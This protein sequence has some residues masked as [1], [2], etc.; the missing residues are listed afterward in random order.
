[1]SDPLRIAIMDFRKKVE[2]HLGKR[3]QQRL[4]VLR[5]DDE[6]VPGVAL[7][8]FQV[9]GDIQMLVA[10]ITAAAVR[11]IH[12]YHRTPPAEDAPA[13]PAPP[14]PAVPVGPSSGYTA[15]I[16]QRLAPV[17]NA[18]AAPSAT[19]QFQ[20]ILDTEMAALT[21]ES[22]LV[23]KVGAAFVP[24][25]KNAEQAFQAGRHS[26]VITILKS[27]LRNEPHNGILLFIASQF[28]YFMASSGQQDALPAAR[29][30]AQKAMIFSDRLP[31]EK[32]AYYRYHCIATE[33]A[34]DMERA[35]TWI[36]EHNLLDIAPLLDDAGLTAQGGMPLKMW[37]VLATIPATFW[38][39]PEL[40]A[41]EQLVHQVI[42]G[43]VLY[44]A[45]LRPKLIEAALGR[46][47]PQPLIDKIENDLSAAYARY[48]AIMPALEQFPIAVGQLPWLVRTRYLNAIA[49]APRP[50]FDHVLL[51][52]N[53]HGDRWQNDV[54]PETEVQHALGER[55]LSY[56]RLWTYALTLRK[57][58]RQPHLLPAVEGLADAALLADA[59]ALLATLRQGEN[60]RIRPMA[61]EEIQPWMIKWQI[62]HLL[63]AGTGTSQPRDTFVPQ[64]SPFNTLY[65]R[66]NDPSAAGLLSSEMIYTTAQRGGFADVS[67]ILTAFEGA[68]RLIDDP[69]YGLHATQKRALKAAKDH[70]PG[71]YDHLRIED[72][73]SGAQFLMMLLPLVLMGGI[74]AVMMM[75]RNMGQAIGLSLALAGF[76]GVAMISLSRK[77]G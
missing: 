12:A 19:A 54:Y 31:P 46:K 58:T 14:P 59:D 75:S 77:D 27:A 10:E 73:F 7:K 43:A 51:H 60:T 5:E 64:I 76:I 69:T 35:L 2:G 39:E 30:M 22:A 66:W 23:G 15:A 1:M 65:R 63:A 13:T 72:G 45:M 57:E 62:D 61:W 24:K 32:L 28:H 6:A 74:A 49:T 44:L 17:L 16:R 56:W 52:I 11:D 71:K 70:N 36:R 21:G 38:G 41:I 40:R 9:A 47:D 3:R 25:L 4:Q 50:A 29:E 48:Q 8:S 34:L 26:D 55:G 67:E 18:A 68:Y 42:G 33:A 37:A 53:L 20:S